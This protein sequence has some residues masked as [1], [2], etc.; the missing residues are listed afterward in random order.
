MPSVPPDSNVEFTASDV[1]SADVWSGKV[2]PP[3]VGIDV[4]CTKIAV[5]LQNLACREPR[6]W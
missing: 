4:A 5:D 1:L 6:A 3:V 2:P